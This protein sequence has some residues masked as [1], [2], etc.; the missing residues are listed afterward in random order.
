MGNDVA[1]PAC[2]LRAHGRCPESV[3]T[4]SS[5]RQQHRQYAH[6]LEA[7]ARRASNFVFSR[8]QPCTA[9]RRISR[10]R[11]PRRCR[12]MPTAPRSSFRNGAS[13]SDLATPRGATCPSSTSTLQVPTP[14]AIGQATRCATLLVKW[15]LQV[16]V[17]KRPHLSRLRHG[18]P[19]SRLYG[20]RTTS[21]SKTWLRPT[22]NALAICGDGGGSVVLSG[23]YGHATVVLKSAERGSGSRP[24]RFRREGRAPPR[25]R[26][27]HA[28]RTCR[29]VRSTLGGADPA[30]DDLSSS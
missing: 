25:R 12:S 22:V 10:T 21:M 27:S 7:S 29:K 30:L 13:R 26:S 3:S 1:S 2:T 9:S 23:G 11:T 6:L 15:A 8:P 28:R 18:L 17:G 20:R 4:R 24:R 19:D 14:A 5:T 16:V